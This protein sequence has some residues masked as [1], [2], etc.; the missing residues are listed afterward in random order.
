[1]P[2][3]TKRVVMVP[4]LACFTV[5]ILMSYGTDKTLNFDR[6]YVKEWTAILSKED[7]RTDYFTSNYSVVE[8]FIPDRHLDDKVLKTIN[9][10]DIWLTCEDL[11]EIDIVKSGKVGHGSRKLTYLGK[12]RDRNVAIKIVSPRVTYAWK[13]LNRF[14][15]PYRECFHLVHM[16]L[17]KE[18]LLLHQLRHPGI[19]KLLGYCVR[20]THP[21]LMADLVLKHGVVAVYEFAQKYEIRNVSLPQRLIYALQLADLLHYLENSPLGSLRMSD[22]RKDNFMMVDGSL[23]IVDVDLLNANEE[24]CSSTCLHD[25]K[26]HNGFCTGLNAKRMMKN[27]HRVFFKQLLTDEKNVYGLSDEL[28]DISYMCENLQLSASGL[29]Q[30]IEGM[31]NKL[32]QRVEG[33]NKTDHT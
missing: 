18:I 23:K 6:N 1:M 14:K 21:P 16:S 13:C 30:E 7:F 25:V 32:R 31:V 9:S 4:A 15:L 33:Y 29:K 24:N 8:E 10:G 3:F 28:T 26:C 2:R 5:F 22:L 20:D 17:M 19:I 12:Y 11:D 27:A